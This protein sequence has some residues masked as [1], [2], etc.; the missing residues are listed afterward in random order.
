[1]GLFAWPTWW[2]YPVAE[3]V[4]GAAA[5]LACRGLKPDDK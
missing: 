3:L 1:M 4:G 2:I 5:G